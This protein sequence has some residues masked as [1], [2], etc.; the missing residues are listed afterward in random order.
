MGSDIN[1]IKRKSLRLSG[2]DYSSVGVYFITICTLS[3]KASF[4]SIVSNKMILSPIGKIARSFWSEIPNHFKNT[5]LDL[6]IIMPNH[7]HGLIKIHSSDDDVA[8]EH[9]QPRNAFQHIT[10]GS[11]VQLSDSIKHLSQ[12]GVISTVIIIFV[13]NEIIMNES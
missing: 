7:I 10:K 5:Q 2:Y 4:G 3:R 12:D 9:V 8:A 13:G 11:M 6:F 1:K